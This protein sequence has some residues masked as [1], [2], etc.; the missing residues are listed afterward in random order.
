LRFRAGEQQTTSSVERSPKM[1]KRTIGQLD[2]AFRR[3]AEARAPII[4]L[5]F[6]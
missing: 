4:I 6:C 5:H 1:S 2:L 3:V